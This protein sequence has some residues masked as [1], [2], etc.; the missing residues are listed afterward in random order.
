MGEL[1][2]PRR[3]SNDA[4]SATRRRHLFFCLASLWGY[5]LGVGVLAAAMSRGDVHVNVD[6]TLA[7]WLLCGSLAGIVGGFVAAGAY[8]EARRRS[9]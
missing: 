3:R 2:V 5:L 8:R 7:L 4:S 6:S 1:E 9:R